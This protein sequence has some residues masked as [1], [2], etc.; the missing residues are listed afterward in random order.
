M[1]LKFRGLIA[2]DLG[3][4]LKKKISMNK[5]PIDNC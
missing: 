5:G 2:I 4:K 3:A 1:K